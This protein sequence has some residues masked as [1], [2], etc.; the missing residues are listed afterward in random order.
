MALFAFFIIAAGWEGGKVGVSVNA[1]IVRG[2]LNN[3]V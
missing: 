2:F 1:V 3:T